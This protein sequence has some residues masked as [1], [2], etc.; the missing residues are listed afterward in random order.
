MFG[1]EAWLSSADG[2]QWHWGC[3]IVFSIPHVGWRMGFKG[4]YLSSIVAVCS[5]CLSLD[6]AAAQELP[7]PVLPNKGSSEG[8]IRGGAI[9]RLGT[10]D[11][12]KFS[13][14]TESV[15]YSPKGDVVAAGADKSVQFWDARTG[16]QLPRNR[17]YRFGVFASVLP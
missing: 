1:S 4:P 8:A 11:L 12:R 13:S 9:T 7:P 6:S 14:Y 17:R 2:K 16:K 3:F 15:A 5:C 10:T